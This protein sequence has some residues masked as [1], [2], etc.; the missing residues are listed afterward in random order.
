MKKMFTRRLLSYMIAAF[1]VTIVF[2]FVLQTFVAQNNN[3]ESSAEKL[4]MIKEKLMSNDNE[5]EKLTNSLSENNL[6]KTRAFA[7]ILASDEAVLTDDKRLQEICEKLMV[8]ELHVID[9]NGIITNSTI[10]DY[11]GFDMNSGEQ[12]AAF[13]AI[14]DDP[15]IEIVQEPQ[16]NVIEGTVIQYIGVARLD[17]KGFVQVG[18]RPEILE[19]TLVNTKIDAV[20]KDIDYGDNGYVYA[21]DKESGQILAHPNETLIGTDAAEAGLV[22]TEGHGKTGIDGTKGYYRSEEY[23]GMIIGTFLPSGEYYETRTNQTFVVA[24]SILVIFITLLVAINRTVDVKIVQGI[25]RLAAS[26]KKIAGGDFDVIADEESNPEFTQLSRDINTMVDSIRDSMK[27][28]ENLLIQQK[29]DM[30]NTV[31]IVENIKDVCRELRIVSQQTLSSAEDIF[32]GTEQ[33]K[34]SVNDLEQVMGT[35]VDELNGSADATVQVTKTT[36]EAV[37]TILDTQKQMT[38]LQNA[39]E[40]INNMSREIEQIIVEIDEI[41]SQTNLLALNASIEA[42]RAGDVGKG[43]AVVATEVGNLATRSAQAA[44]QTNE[45]ISNSIHAISDGMKLTQDT[46]NTFESVVGEIERANAGVEQ[47]ADMVRK[48]VTVVG[49]AMTEIEKITSVVDANTEISESSKQI[50][51]NMADITGRLLDIVG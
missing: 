13:M 5:I 7:E 23:D 3:A 22:V 2:I 1:V 49:Q 43:F 27:D 35:L 28:N 36:E 30:E 46:A 10:S 19:E 21:I 12:S 33:Q 9:K 24:I 14:I 32:R 41:A 31:S 44:K 47:I 11:I 40:K 29:T 50:S 48:N 6:A 4:E 20:M 17:A 38:E 34:Q 18:I 8:N 25:N 42:A 39:I 16:Q 45:L 51:A 37:G 15:T 26:M